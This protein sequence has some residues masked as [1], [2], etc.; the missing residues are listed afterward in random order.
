MPDLEQMLQLHSE[1]LITGAARTSN[2]TRPQWQPPLCT[3]MAPPVAANG[4][5]RARVP[6]SCT[7]A[8]GAVFY[9]G[10]AESLA[11]L[12]FLIDEHQLVGI[13]AEAP[14]FG[15]EALDD[16]GIDARRAR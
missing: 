8:L 1:T 6:A 11:G 12:R 10:S 14:G 16:R 13:E 4:A 3:I 5:R 2:L 9:P 7:L 15:D